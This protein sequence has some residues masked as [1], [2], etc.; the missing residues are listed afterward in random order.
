[1]PNDTVAIANRER[2]A[3]LLQ[4]RPTFGEHAFQDV[5]LTGLTLMHRIS[6]DGMMCSVER[7]A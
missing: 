3:S 2:T 7:S 6:V 1:M 5:G 4:R